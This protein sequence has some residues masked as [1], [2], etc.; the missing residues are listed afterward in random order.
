MSEN[1]REIFEDP[2]TV[3]IKVEDGATDKVHGPKVPSKKSKNIPPAA[4]LPIKG[5]AK[6][7][8]GKRKIMKVKGSFSILS[9]ERPQQIISVQNNPGGLVAI[10]ISSSTRYNQALFYFS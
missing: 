10:P 7:P 9:R 6:T 4:Q 3:T 2:N 1:T 5:Q 8:E